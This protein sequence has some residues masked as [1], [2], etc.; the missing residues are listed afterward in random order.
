MDYAND[1]EWRRSNEG[2]CNSESKPLPNMSYTALLA[3]ATGLVGSQLLTMIIDSDVYE[4]VHV[5][6][7]R[8]LNKS[9]PKIIEHIIDFENIK[10]F[11]PGT[12]IDHVFC[13]LGTTIKKAKT[14]EN[15]RKVDHDYVIDLA[16]KTYEWETSRFLVISALGA[17]AKSNI[18]Y[19]RVKGD[20]EKALQDIGLPHL[21][22]FRPSLLMGDRKENR[23]GEKTAIMVYK[24]INP[25]FVGKL[26]KYKGISANKVA[27]GMLNVALNNENTFQIFE[28]DEIQDL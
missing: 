11:D 21:F 15:F 1:G 5:L 18:F 13:C 8:E 2:L 12:K 22:I 4:K 17:S 27:K 7:R 20:M 26:K 24:V 14:K 6:S 23:P 28:S 9:S 3:G 25:L 16:Q 19:N 10:N